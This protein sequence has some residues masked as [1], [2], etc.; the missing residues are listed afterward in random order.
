MTMAIKTSLTTR[1]AQ[2]MN[3]SI[4]HTVFYEQTTEL[5]HFFPPLKCICWGGTLKKKKNATPHG[6]CNLLRPFSRP[7]GLVWLC[8]CAPRWDINSCLYLDHWTALLPMFPS[9]QKRLPG[10]MA[11]KNRLR[12][13]VIT[14]NGSSLSHP[15]IVPTRSEIM[16]WKACVFSYIYYKSC[17]SGHSYLWCQR[18]GSS[19]WLCME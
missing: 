18:K 10:R 17:K 3:K 13:Y 14:L 7:A 12:W 1:S 9:F 19:A 16:K 6:C 15:F 2:R 5:A 4:L 11:R 8:I